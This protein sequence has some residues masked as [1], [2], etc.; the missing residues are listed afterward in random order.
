MREAAVLNKLQH[1]NIISVKDI[2]RDDSGLYLV[3]DY[4]KC[5]LNALL[6]ENQRLG[7][8]GLYEEDIKVRFDL[9][10]QAEMNSRFPP[11]EIL[12]PTAFRG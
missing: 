2:V 5:D 9:I 4:M 6:G 8:P 7:F 1:P 11:A 3:I 12:P 10:L